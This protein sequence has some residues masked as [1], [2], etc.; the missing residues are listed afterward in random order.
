MKIVQKQEDWNLFD[1]PKA[2][3][4]VHAIPRKPEP[5]RRRPGQ[6]AIEPAEAAKLADQSLAIAIDLSEQLGACSTAIC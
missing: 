6:A 5:V 2:E 1:F 3:K 4:F